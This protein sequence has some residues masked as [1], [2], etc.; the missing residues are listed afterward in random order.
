MIA[1]NRKQ[2]RERDPDR[3]RRGFRTLFVKEIRRYIKV[4]V[5]TVATP[6]IT[7]LLYLVVFR[8]V[9]E[10]RV[11]VYSGVGYSAFLIPGL[12]MMGMIQNAFANSSSS[13]LQSKMNGNLVFLLL[14]PLSSMEI[15]FAFTAAAV[16][17]GLA[18][19]IGV[20]LASLWFV[21]LPLREPL[22]LLTFALVGCATLGALGIIAAIWSDGYDKLSAFSNFVILPLSFLSGVFYSIH[23]LPPLWQKVSQF[24]PFFY[25]ID[26]FR[27]GFL[28]DS[29]I[30]PWISLA[31]SGG[32]L[33]AV[34][35]L[36]VLM[37]VTGYKLRG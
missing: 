17:R 13:L 3:S 35:A 16:T 20:L 30:D 19:G 27:Y 4:M 25:L 5:Q 10:D 37:L 36:C 21:D 18:V 7:A 28:A 22:W 33:A 2:S 6:V 26:G 11:E 29:D 1:Q 34:S 24:N 12:I 14:A 8:Q 32:F 23:S 31:V 15:F 9:L